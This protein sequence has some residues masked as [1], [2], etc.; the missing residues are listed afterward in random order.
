M[1]KFSNNAVGDKGVFRLHVCRR[2]LGG[3][4]LSV[5]SIHYLHKILI[6]Q[7]RFS[8]IKFIF[9]VLITLFCHSTQKWKRGVVGYENKHNQNYFL[10]VIVVL[11]V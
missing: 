2:M 6:K 4:F 1:A 9:L 5:L 11:I 8:I 7:V 3:Y 10:M